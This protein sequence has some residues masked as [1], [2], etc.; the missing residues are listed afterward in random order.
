MTTDQTIDT[1]LAIIAFGALGLGLLSM[2]VGWLVKTYDQLMSRW[3][4]GEVAPAASSLETD[5]RQPP[6][7]PAPP[8]IRAEELLTLCKLMRLAGIK[9]EDA[10]AAFTA[11]G[12]PFNNNVWAS[13]AP[14]PPADDY[15]T[16]IAGRATSAD[17]Y[18]D[19]PELAYRPPR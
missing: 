8:K 11:S 4:A 9:R 12:L 1:V 19:E 3:V 2:L 13:A 7:A 16:P 17:Y 15:R 10:Q 6:D 5:A 14:P 18:P